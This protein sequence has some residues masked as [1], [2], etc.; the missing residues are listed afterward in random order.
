MFLIRIRTFFL[1]TLLVC[2]YI[3]TLANQ[4][5]DTTNKK[6]PQLTVIFVLDQFS[7][8]YIPKLGN[9]FRH[10]LKELLNKGINYTQAYHAH[11]IPE[12]T[13][14]HHALSTGCMPKIHGAVLNQW[15]REDYKKREY[16]SDEKPNTEEFLGNDTLG[17]GKSYANSRV[18]G[19]SDQFIRGAQG[20]TPRASYALA[21]KDHPAISCANHLGKAIWFD[22]D[23]GGFCS[24]RSYFKELPSWI[25]SFNDTINYKAMKHVVWEPCYRLESACY[26]YPNVRNF[27]GSTYNYSLID[28]RELP[29]E[30]G[31]KR[32][33]DFYMKAPQSSA[34]LLDLTFA[35]IE[36]ELE[37]DDRTQM[38]MWVCLSNLDLCG[39]FV[40][41]DRLEMIDMLYH[42]DQQ[43]GDFMSK[44]RRV[45]GKSNCLFAVTGDHGICPIPELTASL[46]VKLGKRLMAQDIMKELNKIV[47]EEFK[48]DDVVKAFEPTYFVL[49]KELLKQQPKETRI[50]IVRRLKKH[51]L[52][53]EGIK[54]VWTVKELQKLPFEP[55]DL[56]QF[57]KNQIYKGR[58]GDLICMPEPY[59][60]ITNYPS[61]TSHL[62]PY[63]YDTHV[64][65]AVY[66]PGNYEK[67]IINERVW[68]AQLPVLLADILHIQ[69]PSASAY[70]P[71]PTVQKK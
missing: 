41:P 60:L 2:H 16:E 50:E 35:C 1:L 26:N 47:A 20:T 51:L 27:T 31:K 69:K 70:K 49:N 15:I 54:K 57:Y 23:N 44:I 12:T 14:G 62:S 11:G 40:G 59:C 61:G 56:E 24:S 3:T 32:A 71:L 34:D 7:Y 42:I 45:L 22:P 28:K 37:T 21:I 55:N 65:L 5:S 18:D 29:I 52:S 19:L 4:S 13:P 6:I 36:N 9:H 63:E 43:I 30:H 8:A 68:V 53:M 38:L 39:H 10:G 66:W 17:K 64:P 46:G 33:F 58:T 25:K 67:T 48:L